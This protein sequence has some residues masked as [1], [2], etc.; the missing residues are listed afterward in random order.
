[1]KVTTKS[2][3]TLLTTLC[4]LAA[5]LALPAQSS[6]AE[7]IVRVVAPTDARSRP[8]MTAGRVIKHL[9]TVTPYGSEQLQLRVL[10]SVDGGVIANTGGMRRTWY[11]AHLPYR[12]SSRDSSNGHV[13]WVASDRVQLVTTPF[14]IT[15]NRSQRKLTV[16]RYGR[17][18]KHWRIVVGASSMPTPR[19]E[20]AIYGKTTR[21][22]GFDGTGLTP[23]AYSPVLSQ[24]DGGPGMVAMHGRSGASMNDPL[25]T[26][27]SHGCVRMDNANMEIIL[28][29]MPIGTPVSVR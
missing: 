15:I 10:R 23:F 18:W 7:R 24:F 6:A 9:G 5:M 17:V 2:A 28:A 22:H 4:M 8:S 20:F 13:G 25:G 11:L 3:I 29:R 19:G 26:A 12:R 16:T 21:N 14:H 1:M 27:R